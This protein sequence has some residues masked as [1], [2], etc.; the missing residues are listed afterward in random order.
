MRFLK[1][2]D[3]PP[4][5]RIRRRRRLQRR[6]LYAAAGVVILASS[7]A[8]AWYVER[9]GRLAGILAQ[10]ETRIAS[11]GAQLDLTVESVQLVGRERADRQAILNALGVKRGSPILSV[12]LD[13]AKARLETV[14]WI[15]SA[16][17]ERLLPDT[18]YV[19]VVERKPLALWQHDGRFDLVDQDGNIIANADIAAFPALPQVVG[20]DAPA[21]TPDLLALM[22][23]EP[24]LQRHVTAA[25]RVGGRRWNIDFDNGIE[26]ALPEDNAVGAW[27]R[28]AALDRSDRILERDVQ[29]ID[30]RL[31]D[32]IGLRLAPDVAKSLIKKTKPPQASPNT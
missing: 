10:S 4:P 15:R 29:A 3:D 6:A 24:A 27:H 21:A 28:L 31:P 8:G 26:V 12:D 23:A 18:L 32:R 17:I 9:D 1:R 13:A 25:I 11:L 16:S 5:V 19:R 14:P 2:S 22:A 7:A 20:D 30:M